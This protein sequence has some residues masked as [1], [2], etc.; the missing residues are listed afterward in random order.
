MKTNRTLTALGLGFAL[1]IG[2]AT[3]ASPAWLTA[4]DA[5]IKQL[6]RQMTLVEKA[7]QMTQPNVEV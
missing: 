7:G 3:A 4:H 2:A 5:E 6:V 1:S